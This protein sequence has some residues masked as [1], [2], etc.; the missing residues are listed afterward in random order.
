MDT[1]TY[2][3]NITP[4]PTP[5]PRL[6]RFK[7]YNEKKYTQYKKS[8]IWLLKSLKIP[9]KDYDY[10]HSRFFYPYPKNTPKKRFIDK[11]PLRKNFDCDN[12]VKGLLDSLEQAQVIQNDRQFTA[13]YVEKYYTTQDKGRIEFDLQEF[14]ID[15][16]EH[17]SVEK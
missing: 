9:L 17:L 12:V 14:N 6:G 16:Y 1:L 8:I 4:Q 13:I 7:V 2:T 5:R 11:Y 15:N 10:I 3:L